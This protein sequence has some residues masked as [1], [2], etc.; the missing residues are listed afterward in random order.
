MCEFVENY[1][2]RIQRCKI[3]YSIK[4]CN[5]DF[6]IQSHDVFPSGKLTELFVKFLVEEGIVKERVIADIGAGSFALGIVAVLNGAKKAIGVDINKKSVE[7][8]KQNINIHSVSDK[9]EILH[10]GIN[11]LYPLFQNK[12]DV[13]VSGLPWDTISLKE[14]NNINPERKL[15]A[16]AFYDVDDELIN[17]ILLKGFNLLNKKGQIFITSSLQVLNRMNNIFRQYNVIYNIVKEEDIHQD[18]NI[19][20]ILKLKKEQAE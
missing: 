1:I 12:I 13:L 14:F 11:K 5:V 8:A 2:E 4:I 18:G 15:L 6:I 10:G 16:R 9:A 7:C 3:P 17:S 19:H 20:Y